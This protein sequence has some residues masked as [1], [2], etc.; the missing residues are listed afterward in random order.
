MWKCIFSST[1]NRGVGCNR[2]AQ[3]GEFARDIHPSECGWFMSDPSRY[4]W[5]GSKLVEFPGWEAEVTQRELEAARERKFDEIR[6]AYREAL[7]TP[8]VTTL[9]TF[10]GGEESAGAINGAIGLAQFFSEADVLITD[11][12][13]RGKRYSYGDAMLI[14]ASIGKAARDAFYKKQEL[15]CQA[16]DALPRSELD[17]IVW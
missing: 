4:M 6:A 2:E 3:D 7:K 15:M 14:A 1:T 9:G 5:D 8:V 16:A 12:A 17:A 10:T 13:N 11:A